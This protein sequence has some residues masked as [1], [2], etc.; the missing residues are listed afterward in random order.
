[1][2][3]SS[4]TAKCVEQVTRRNRV[5]ESE[6]LVWWLSNSFDLYF[7][8]SSVSFTSNIG[9]SSISCL[10]IYSVKV[11][12]NVS[13]QNSWI[14][15]YEDYQ[16]SCC[17]SNFCHLS[18][19]CKYLKLFSSQVLTTGSKNWDPRS[20]EDN[21]QHWRGTQCWATTVSICPISFESAIEWLRQHWYWFSDNAATEQMGSRQ[22]V[23]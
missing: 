4:A 1:M 10:Q 2:V 12:Y 14:H 13:I 3:T 6:T 22:S 21:F 17:C 18:L 23:Q 19:S 11:V 8:C 9:D 16:L 20:F 15:R 7:H 5:S